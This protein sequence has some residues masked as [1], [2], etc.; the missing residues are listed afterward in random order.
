VKRRILVIQQRCL[1][2]T[3]LK[4]LKMERFKILKQTHFVK[5]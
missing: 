4:K 1:I 3:L 2:Q 5:N